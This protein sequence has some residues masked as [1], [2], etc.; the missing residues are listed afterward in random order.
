M[1]KLFTPVCVGAFDSRYRV[2][3]KDI[4]DLAL[5]SVP[6]TGRI[7]LQDVVIHLPSDD[8]AAVVSP[9]SSAPEDGRDSM[10]SPEKPDIAWGSSPELRSGLRWLLAVTCGMLI[11]NVYF[12]QPL[13]GPIS[14]ALGM[15]QQSAGFIVTLPLMGYGVGLLMLVPLG[16][17][18]ENRRLI[19]VMIAVEAACL[20][21]ISMIS[22][23]LAFLVTAFFIGM[24]A[25][26]VQVILP[27]VSHLTAE[28]ARGRALG[29]LVSGIML[30]IMLARPVSSFVADLGSW[31][32]I[33]LISGGATVLVLFTLWRTIPRRAPVA[34]PSYGQLMGSMGRIY[35]DSE[36]LRRR[37]LYHAAMFGAFSV[38][39]T[40]APLWLS[41]APFFL[42]QNGIAWVAVAGVAGAIAPPFAGRLSDRGLAGIGTA[43]AMALAGL[44]FALSNLG[45]S[46]GSFGLAMV[47]MTAVLLDF[48]VS[49]NLVFGQ[50]A[51]YT[52]GAE[53][54]SRINALFM[55][56]FFAGGAVASG[57]S[58][59]IFARY[60]W[61]G[62]S[63][64]GIGL[65]LLALLYWTTERRNEATQASA[66]AAH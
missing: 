15:P 9:R 33:Y 8:A 30:G 22:Q 58:G 35:R 61:T 16:D 38:F 53:E 10:P 59:W 20:L 46:G 60:G 57:L 54:R 48:A 14:A 39:W 4:A 47:V 50:R 32:V 5:P 34:G 31:R 1:S 44:S 26:A 36:I 24:S 65:P 42:S 27:Y 45:R 40:A 7:Q 41:G 66:N 25:S 18:V 6:T 12:G 43:A 13:T 29:R 23:A 52:L 63:M 17:L 11:A 19:L 3:E 21:T 64:L 55:A 37:A 62:V 2:T 49:A 28:A 56:T 51:I